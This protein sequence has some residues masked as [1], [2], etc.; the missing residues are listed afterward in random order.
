MRPFRNDAAAIALGI[1]LQFV[2]S[3]SFDAL[4][5]RMSTEGQDEWYRATFDAPLRMEIPVG[6]TIK[7]PLSVT[8]SGRVRWEPDRSPRIRLSYHWL[9]A[10]DDRVVSWEGLRTDFASA[11]EPGQTVSVV[12]EVEAPPQ[13]GVYRLLWDLEEERRLWF[14]TEPNAALFTSRAAV[15]GH[16]GAGLDPASFKAFPK[17]GARPGRFVLWRAAGRML[18]DRP[19]T[20]VGP[21][22]YRLLYGGYAGLANADERVHSNNLYLEILVSG[23]LVAG[24]VLAWIGWRLAM[25]SWGAVAPL[26]VHPAAPGIVAAVAALA[27]HGLFDAFL[28]FTATYVLTA[29]TIGLVAGLSMSARAHA[30]GV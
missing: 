4:R 3:R 1:G 22:N 29:I 6:G 10:D 21:D 27:V 12:A 7:V 30:E 28:A 11:V 2:A 16:Q 24:L 18:A 23:G 26:A 15:T 19:W 25:V 17:S 5:L 14:S 9:L 20:G 8:N 13:P